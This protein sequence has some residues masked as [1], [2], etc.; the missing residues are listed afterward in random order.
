MGSLIKYIL[1]D[2]WIFTGFFLLVL[3]VGFTLKSIAKYIAVAFKG[4]PVESGSLNTVKNIN[5]VI[6]KKKPVKINKKMLEKSLRELN[7]LEGL[8]TLKNE[9]NELVLLTKY[10]IEENEFDPKISSMHMVFHG[11]SGTGKTTVARI[12]ADIYKSLGVLS[13][14]QLVEVDRASLVAGFI[15]QTAILTQNKINEAIGG[16]LFIDEAYALVQGGKEDF[17]N[18]AINTILKDMEDRKGEF[19]VIVAGYENEM[20]DFLEANPGLRS[21]FDKSFTFQDHGPKELWNICLHMIKKQNKTI[22]EKGTEILKEYI[23]NISENRTESF[24]NAREIRKVFYEIIKNQKLRLSSIS[25][26]ERTPNKK[27]L[28]IAEDVKEFKERLVQQKQYQNIG[29]RLP[30]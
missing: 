21:R 10:D 5:K 19:I 27:K 22:D 14:G 9:I 6:K 3:V 17:G 4:W 16:I 12:I 24:G 30:Q 20:N 23:E 8:H 25:K 28:I 1:S 15:G 26:N 2:F 7:K 18:E 11:N 13:T 29:F